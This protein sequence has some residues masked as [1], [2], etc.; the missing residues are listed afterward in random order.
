MVGG[1]IDVV[2]C[3]I[4][5]TQESFENVMKVIASKEE[6]ALNIDP[7]ELGKFIAEVTK[8]VVQSNSAQ[9]LVQQFDNP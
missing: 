3:G 8:T 5:M 2:A 9:V 1:N 4:G 7:S 6:L